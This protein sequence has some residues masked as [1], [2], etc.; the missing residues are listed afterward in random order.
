MKDKDLSRKYDLILPH[1]DEKTKRLYVGSEALSL[2][3]GGIAIVNLTSGVSRTTI[4][5]GIRELEK[6]KTVEPSK[7]QG[8]RKGG[9]GRKKKIEKLEGLSQAL[10]QLLAP[11]TR[12]DPMNPLIWT[13]K[14]LRQLEKELKSQGF[15]VSYRVIGDTLKGMGYSLQANRKT[16]EGGKHVDRDAQFEFINS[17]SIEYFKSGNPV[18]SVDCKKKELI[19]DFKNMGQEWEL[20]GKS[21]QVQVYDFIDKE[22]GKA[23][24]YGIYDI[25]QNEG[26]V[27]VGISHDTAEF[28][29]SSIRNWWD[30]MGKKNYPKANKLYINADGGGSN[31]SRNR[32]WKMMLQQLAQDTGLEIRVSHFP[33]GTSKWNKIEHRLFSFITMN[34]RAKPL[35]SL[36]TIVSLIAST[37]TKSGLKVQAAPD[38]KIYQTAIK[39]TDEDMKKINLIKEEF[40]GE[41]NYII[42]PD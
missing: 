13:S 15:A 40:H 34:W 16:K 20:K 24:P 22:K 32:L 39:V 37:T 11:H 8:I 38:E 30:K 5:Q 7:K 3:R 4:S 21:P 29:V 42:N 35:V 31:G 2:G 6:G 1:L 27:S 28:A 12:G 33:P 14:S 10:E 23:A 41:W 9:G 17:Q 26:W 25:A 36:H 18:I 19:G